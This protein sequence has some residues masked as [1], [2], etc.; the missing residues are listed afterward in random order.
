M[1]HPGAQGQHPGQPGQPAGGPQAGGPPPPPGKDI[2]VNFA[3]Y[4]VDPSWRRLPAPEK[5]RQGKE[6][7]ETL[8]GRAADL[9][10]RLRTYSLSGLRGDADLMVWYIGPDFSA[11]QQLGAEVYRTSLGQYL[12]ISNAYSAM[13]RPTVY[14]A[15]HPQA[16]EQDLPELKYLVVYPFVKTRDWYLM[17]KDA[18]Q[19]MMNEHMK[20]GREYPSVRL[21]T[22][23]SFGIGDQDHVVAFETDNLGDFQ[24]L[25]MRLR[26]AQASLYTVRDT[27]MYVCLTKPLEQCVADLG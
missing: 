13:R 20:I 17:S 19:G 12:V 26:E 2:F 25:V 18:R 21:N 11:I 4:R 3:F 10:I 16:F 6:F 27:P 22:T 23:Y 9:G 1:S 24:E 14:G 8:Q 5:E 7:T 15:P